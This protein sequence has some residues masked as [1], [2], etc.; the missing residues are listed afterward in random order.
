MLELYHYEPN[1]FSLKALIGLNEKGVD[2]TSHYV[3]WVGLEQL[4]PGGPELNLEAEHNPEIE[5][6]LLVNGE[7]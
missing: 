1:T 6:P 4:G 3:D 2:Y 5:G 7:R